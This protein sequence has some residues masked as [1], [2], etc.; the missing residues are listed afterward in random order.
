MVKSVALRF[1]IAPAIK[2]LLVIEPRVPPDSLSIA[3]P[4]LDRVP[5]LTRLAMEPAF[6]IPAVTPVMVPPALLVSDM[7]EP[8]LR[9]PAVPPIMLVL[10]ITTRELAVFSKAGTD[11]PW[12]KP[13]LVRVPASADAV[14]AGEVADVSVP[15]LINVMFPPDQLTHPVDPTTVTLLPTDIHAAWASLVASNESAALTDKP[16]TLCLPS[17]STAEYIRFDISPPPF[18]YH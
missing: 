4:L 12:S 18:F 8:L 16:R 7:I 1:V 15:L 11:V 17:E 3:L 13:L 14:S 5:L 9:I 2:P 10:F 6:V